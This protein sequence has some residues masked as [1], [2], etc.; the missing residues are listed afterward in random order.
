MP[1]GTAACRQWYATTS[2]L[3]TLTRIQQIITT[4]SADI[5]GYYALEIGTLAGQH[6]FLQESRIA[7]QFALGMV[8][9]EANSLISIPE[10]LPIAFSNIDLIVASHVLD[11]SSNPHQILR[12]IERVLVPEGHCILISFNPF[13]LRG[14]GNAVRMPMSKRSP[15]RCYSSLRLREW[16]QVLGFD[17]LETVSSGFCYPAL[18]KKLGSKRAWL[19]QLG[20]Q[21]HVATGNVYIMHAQKK[22]SNMTPLMPTLKVPPILKPGMIVNPDT[23]RIYSPRGQNGK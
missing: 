20:D 17:V 7:S 6:T 9:G 1:A 12:E 3:N 19:G 22:V 15:W 8:E 23:G 5:F 16:L 4:M 10:Q 18:R 14:L 2:G 21:Y 11:Y 13:S